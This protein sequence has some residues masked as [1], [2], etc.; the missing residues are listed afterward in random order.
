MLPAA[1]TY[2]ASSVAARDPAAWIQCRRSLK[3][4]GEDKRAEAPTRRTGTGEFQRREGRFPAHTERPLDF[5]SPWKII[6]PLAT[7]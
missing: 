5:S 7:K 2:K 4:P 6:H 3:A 1:N